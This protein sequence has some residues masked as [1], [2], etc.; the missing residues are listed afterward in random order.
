MVLAEHLAE[1]K[2][3]EAGPARQ[4][5]SMDGTDLKSLMSDQ[6]LAVKL[7]FLGVDIPMKMSKTTGKKAYAFAKTD[8]AFTALLEHDNPMVQALV[9]ARLGHKIDA[10]GDPHRAAAVDRSLRRQDAGAAQILRRAHA[11]L[12]RRLEDQPAEP[13]A[14]R[15]AAQGVQGTRRA[16]S[17]WRSTPARSRRASTPCCPVQYRL[18]DGLPGRRDV[19]SEFA[20]NIYGYPNVTK[21]STKRALRRQDSHPV[22]GLRLV[23]AGVPEHVPATGRRASF[24][25]RRAC[26]SSTSTAPCIRRSCRTGGTPTATSCRASPNVRRR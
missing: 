2:A 15:R 16:R 21:Q 13:A 8:K 17:W 24:R 11:S 14:R 7:L 6:Q 3:T 18:L 19:Y 10:G 9:A 5:A 1:V 12:Q 25:C 4:P 23:L 20:E 22:A 26:A